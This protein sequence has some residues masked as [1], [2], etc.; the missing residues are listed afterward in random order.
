MTRLL[1]HVPIN[2]GV[3]HFPRHEVLND[4]IVYV[5]LVRPSVCN[6]VHQRG[7]IFIIIGAGSS[8]GISLKELFRLGAYRTTKTTQRKQ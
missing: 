7:K 3:L 5:S 8:D 6:D 1:F 2:A 4:G